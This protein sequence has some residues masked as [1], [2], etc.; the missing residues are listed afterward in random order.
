[1]KSSVVPKRAYRLGARARAAEETAERIVAAFRRRIGVDW[2]DAITLEEIAR[3]AGVTVP[4][5]IRRFGGKERLLEAAWAMFNEEITARRTVEPGDLDGAV[6][7]IVDD[8][9]AVGDVIM[10]ALMQEERIPALLRVNNR[11]RAFHRAWIEQSFAPW[12]VGLSQA[13]R[14]Q[15]VDALVAATDLYTWKLVRR[16]M[17]RSPQHVR[18]IMRQLINGALGLSG[19]QNG[20]TS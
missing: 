5:I 14:R 16:D 10:R 4:T 15:R 17:G 19:A 18:A 13:A 12:L 3:E 7:V 11:G 2:Y 6:R 20:A 9:E 8:Y 1:M